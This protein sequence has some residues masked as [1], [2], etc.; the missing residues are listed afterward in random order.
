MNNPLGLQTPNTAEPYGRAALAALARLRPRHTLF[1]GYALDRWPGLE[2]HRRLAARLRARG[3]AVLLRCYERD[4]PQRDPDAWAAECAERAEAFFGPT[5]SGFG[6]LIPGNEMNWAGLA[7]GGHDD[8]E[9]HRRWFRDFAVTYRALRPDDRL[10]LPG[11]WSGW[12]GEDDERAIRYWCEL[13]PILPLYDVLDVHAYADGWSASTGSGQALHRRCRAILSQA[14]IVLPILV[15]EFNRVPFQ[16]AA[17]DVRHTAGLEGAVY[18]I[19]DSPDALFNEF[20]LL[21]NRQRLAEFAAAQRAAS[22]IASAPRTGRDAGDDPPW[23][24]PASRGEGRGS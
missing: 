16:R 11:P 12:V 8:Y 1:L 3:S 10:H 17:E 19:L 6:E 20:S 21:Q 23:F 22:P 5:E 24:P 18:F 4:I 9:Q 13:L 7:E 15:T 2:Q 14:G